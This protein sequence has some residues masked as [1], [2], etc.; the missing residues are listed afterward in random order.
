MTATTTRADG[1]AFT[2]DVA[3]GGVEAVPA[4]YREEVAGKLRAIQALAA[5]VL[6]GGGGR[7]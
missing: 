6:G 5:A 4:A 1:S 2:V 7:Q 3:A